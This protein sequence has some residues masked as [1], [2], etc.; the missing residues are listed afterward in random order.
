MRLPEGEGRLTK[1]TLQLVEECKISCGARADQARVQKQWKLTGSPDGN[2]AIFNRLESHIDR[3]SAYLFSPVDLRFL[4]EFEHDYP[5]DVLRQADVSARYLT[6]QVE[7][8]GIDTLFSLGVNEALTHGSAVLK[9]GW[10]HN[11]LGARLIPHWNMGVYHEGRMAFEEQEVILETTYITL[12]ELWRRISHLPGAP[13]MYKRAKAYA[14]KTGQDASEGS[15]FQQVTLSGSS[16]IVDTTGTGGSNATAGVIGVD[17]SNYGPQL[18]P[19][20]LGSLVPFHE[21]TIQD[22]ITGDYT[23][24]QLVEPDILITPRGKK[25]NLFLKGQH[26][27][28][29]IQPNLTPGYFW[30]RSELT[31][32][33]KMQALLRDRLEDVKKIMGLQYDRLL[34][35]IGFSGMG[36]EKY[37]AFREAGYV[38]EDQPGAKVED[39]TPKLPDAAFADIKEILQFMDDIS[40]FHNILGGQGESGVRSGNH[41][42][43]L[44]KTASPRMR[45][46][47]TIVERQCAMMGD[48]AFNLLAMKEAKVLWTGDGTDDKKSFLLAQ[49]PEDHR[50]GVDSHSASPV[51]EEDHKQMAAFLLKAG[52]IDGESVLDLLNLPM[53]DLLKARF[54]RIKAEKAAF[55]QQHPEVLTKGKAKK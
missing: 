54:S 52:I 34:A 28:V 12:H 48:K 9:L 46:K 53:R 39:L 43:T 37:D 27:Y 32:L 21:L 2:A 24:V 6:K 30:G 16:P 50:I 20:I 18:A 1:K 19:E 3:L 41:A 31:P 36:D 7:G 42:Q 40:G 14:K 17:G 13:D 10:G 23:T 33:L 55:L 25:H 35:F 49:L 26:G 15:Y 47:A 5:Q 51:Y 8:A 11:G 4:M 22:D 38:V 44:L 29:K 45:Q